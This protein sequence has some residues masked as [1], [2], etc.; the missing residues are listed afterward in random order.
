MPADMP[1]RFWSSG[2]MSL[3]FFSTLSRKKKV[4]G[5]GGLYALDQ[6]SIG[7]LRTEFERIVSLR[8]STKKGISRELSE[9]GSSA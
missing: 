6:S 7:D 8:I 5:T 9:K 2:G 3:P 4:A 1:L